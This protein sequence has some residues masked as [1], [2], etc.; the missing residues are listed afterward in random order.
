MASCDVFHQHCAT[1][2]VSPSSLSPVLVIEHDLFN[3]RIVHS[4]DWCL[5]LALR[6][7][8]VHATQ[9]EEEEDL[10]KW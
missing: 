6:T 2:T 10:F 7:P 1:S 4:G 5:R 8:V 9:E 3:L